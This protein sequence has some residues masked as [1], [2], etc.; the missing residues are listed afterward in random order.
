MSENC[1]VCKAIETWD[2]QA[3]LSGMT[4]FV[5]LWTGGAIALFALAFAIAF[6]GMIIYRRL[7]KYICPTLYGN[8]IEHKKWE[9]DK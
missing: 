5:L 3:Y 2:A 9:K 1:D 8:K 6:S 4:E 7:E